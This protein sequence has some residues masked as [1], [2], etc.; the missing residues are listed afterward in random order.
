MGWRMFLSRSARKGRKRSLKSI[1]GSWVMDEWLYADRCFIMLSLDVP[2]QRCG[3]S[4]GI[5]NA[6]IPLGFALFDFYSFL[7]CVTKGENI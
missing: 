1:H 5:M 6:P 2:R 4:H 3:Q 7:I